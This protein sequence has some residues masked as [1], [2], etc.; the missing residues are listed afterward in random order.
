M[1]AL[2]SLRRRLLARC[3]LPLLIAV[4][5]STPVGAVTPDSPEVLALIDKG[6]AYLAKPENTDSRLGAKCLIAL[7]FHK[8]GLPDDSPRIQEAVEACGLQF[9]PLEGEVFIYNKGVAV[10]FLSELD[11]AKYRELIDRYAGSLK[12]HQKPH[13]GF[14]Y[15]NYETGDTSQTQYA[16]LAYWEMLNHGMTPKAE[17]V[18]QC[19]KWLMRSA[20]SLRGVGIS[21]AGSR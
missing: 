19:L 1:L 2:S 12:Q 20:R 9:E 3:G 18:Q 14:G 8:R 4:L 17:S 10:I 7:A 16:A 11:S 13:G 6:L 5:A 15:I 21:G